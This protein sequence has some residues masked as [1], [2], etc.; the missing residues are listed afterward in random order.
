LNAF[1]ELF[2]GILGGRVL[3]VA[4]GE[5]G[6][7]P[8]LQRYLDGYESITGVDNNRKVLQTARTTINAPATHFIQM[9][10]EC[11]G[12]ADHPFNVVSISASLHHLENVSRILAE[13]R[14]VL[15]S[16][17]KFI[18]TE[19]HRDGSSTAQFNA[20][21]IHHWAAAV[22][23]RLGILHDRTFARQEILSFIDD[24]NLVNLTT[25][26]F[27]SIKGDPHDD[28]AIAGIVRYMDRYHQRLEKVP[29]NETLVEQETELRASLAE[30]GFQREPILLVIAEKP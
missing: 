26:D 18:L 30:K 12:F 3:D 11:L 19:M 23:T 1:E 27:S 6:Y 28:N 25:R 8:I 4:T 29:R 5:A 14:R 9:D 10:G 21:R 13:V 2:S 20:I 16:G 15:R 22:D 7:I 24:L 17:G